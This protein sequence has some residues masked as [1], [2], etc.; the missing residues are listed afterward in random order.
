MFAERVNA[1]LLCKSNVQGRG[2]GGPAVGAK[3]LPLLVLAT[4]LLDASRMC[5]DLL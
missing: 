2:V 3:V 1:V 5:F 4:I